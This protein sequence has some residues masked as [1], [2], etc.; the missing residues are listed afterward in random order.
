MNQSWVR[1]FIITTFVSLYLVVS[2]ISTIHVI[3]FF[4][5]SNPNWLAISLAIAFELGAAA[6]LASLIAL[7]K[8]N[9]ALIWFLFILLTAMQMMGNTYY[10]FTHLSDYQGWVDL[11]GLN[12]D[13]VLYQKRFLSIISGAILPIVALGFIKSLVDYI[14]PSE[15]DTIEQKRESLSISEEVT[16]EK[17][18]LIY[19]IETETVEEAVEEKVE[20]VD[21]IVFDGGGSIF[22]NTT[23][24]EPKPESQEELKPDEI[25]EEI[26]KAPDP[27][28][29]TF[30][31]NS[32]TSINYVKAKSTHQ[33]VYIDP[34]KII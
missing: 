29:V 11:F 30:I 2:I 5:L 25:I 12:E 16:Q 24:P 33:S 22:G 8:M 28:V 27:D 21:D 23:P 18:N 13:D 7:D 4:R 3:D 6:S 14:R 20:K 15:I 1:V 26:P 17:E 34:T 31:E 19:P 9:K 10:A 32:P